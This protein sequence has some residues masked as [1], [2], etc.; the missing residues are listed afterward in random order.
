[1]RL[2]LKHIP[3]AV[4]TQPKCNTV[5]PRLQFTE[6]LDQNCYASH[7]YIDYSIRLER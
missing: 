2:L 6:E 1:M 4:M 7:V 5:T 3:L